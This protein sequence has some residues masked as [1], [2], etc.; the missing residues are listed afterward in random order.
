MIVTKDWLERHAT[1]GMGWTYKQLKAI[2]VETPPRSGWKDRVVGLQITDEQ[3]KK[4]VESRKKP[5]KAKQVVKSD[6]PPR[7]GKVCITFGR[8]KGL[9]IRHIPVDY[10]EWVLRAGAGSD[11]FRRKV[12]VHLKSR[13]SSPSKNS[14]PKTLY[15]CC[16][17]YDP[18]IVWPD[19]QEWDGQSAPWE[20]QKSP[21]AAIDPPD[22]IDEWTELEAA[23]DREYK[24]IVG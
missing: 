19:K 22:I 9:Q 23:L 8:H 12:T 21:I 15:D 1:A 13:T 5:R 16:D 20:D 3:A 24:A 2:G 18:N 11:D 10:L 17:R 6:R 7:V 4:F 14:S